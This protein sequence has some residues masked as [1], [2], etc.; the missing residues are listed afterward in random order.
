MAPHEDNINK[1]SWR[2]AY[3]F[4]LMYKSAIRVQLIIYAVIVLLA[5][6]FLIEARTLSSNFN[7]G[8]YTILS[9]VIAYLL[10]MGPLAF[11]KRD[12][13]LIAQVPAKTSEKFVFYLIYSLIVIPLFTE[14]IWFGLNY[15]IGIFNDNANIECFARSFVSDKYGFNITSSIVILTVINT[16]IQTT[17]IALTVLYVILRSRFHRMLKGIITPLAIIFIIGMI[18]GIAGVVMALSCLDTNMFID[19]KLNE[20]EFANQIVSN[21]ASI[22]IIIDAALICYIVLI[23]YL[24]YRVLQKRQIS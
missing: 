3:E 9:S 22:S 15:G 17:S 5:Y 19:D 23:G 12:D 20:I 13:S 24:S 6:L 1:F 2:R 21:M 16:A 18:S 14:A 8:L 4:G 10:Y 7:M 11:A